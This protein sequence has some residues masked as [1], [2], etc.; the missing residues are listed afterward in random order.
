MFNF[1]AQSEEVSFD[2]AANGL[3]TATPK[4]GVLF[5]SGWVLVYPGSPSD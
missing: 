5:G 3:N 2:S 4:W 1:L